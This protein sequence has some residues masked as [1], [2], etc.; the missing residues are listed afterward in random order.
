MNGIHRLNRRSA[1]PNQ[2][3]EAIPGEYHGQP[4]YLLRYFHKLHDD[5]FLG[6]I[7]GRDHCSRGEP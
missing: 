1:G 7:A 6:D 4:E 3:L 5:R 2:N